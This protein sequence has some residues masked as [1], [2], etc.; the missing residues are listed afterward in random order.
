[1]KTSLE[2]YLA[3][4]CRESSLPHWKACG[5][6]VPENMLILHEEDFHPSLLADYIDER[7]FRLKHDLACIESPE[8]PQRFSL[9]NASF[10]EFSAH[11]HD[12]Y[13]TIR[14][15]SDELQRFISHTVYDP[16]LW[17]AVQS[18][19]TGAIIASGIGTLD[20]NAREGTL[21][22]IQVS[23][24]YRGMGLGKFVVT[25]LLHRMKPLASFATVSGQ[26][27]NRTNP[28][29]LYRSCGFWGSDI[30]HILRRK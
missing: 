1:M 4:P 21:E 7:Y 17:L 14:L 27:D 2:R 8:L 13:D 12:C 29:R 10:E 24:E 16:A 11:I 19:E 26:C 25:A 28:E 22:W 3:N 15:P 5:I 6:Q 18:N 9:R 23:E 30:W 20:R